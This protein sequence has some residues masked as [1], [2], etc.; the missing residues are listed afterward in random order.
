MGRPGA[1]GLAYVP[2]T[3]TTI[4]PRRCYARACSLKKSDFGAYC[5]R[6]T[7]ER[8][9]FSKGALRAFGDGTCLRLPP[10]CRQA[11]RQR[12]KHVAAALASSRAQLRL[13]KQE[14]QQRCVLTSCF[15]R[16]STG[17]AGHGAHRNAERCMVAASDSINGQ[18]SNFSPSDELKTSP[19]SSKFI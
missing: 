1:W 11:L 6:L 8:P 17:G 16:S 14:R 13:S 18:V 15:G 10:P 19:S 12:R 7:K 2:P 4:E 3:S 9:K 5:F